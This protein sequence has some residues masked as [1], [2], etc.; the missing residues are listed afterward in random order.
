MDQSRRA[1]GNHDE[2]FRSICSKLVATYPDLIEILDN[3]AFDEMLSSGAQA[4][5]A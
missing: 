4:L 2:L 5:C 1:L 3:L